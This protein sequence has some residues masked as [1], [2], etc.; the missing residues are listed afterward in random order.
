MSHPGWKLPKPV[1]TDRSL[2]REQE[3]QIECL[4]QEI[5]QLK[6]QIMETNTY[7]YK[8]AMRV[9]ALENAQQKTSTDLS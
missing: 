9:D 3:S 2:I 1:I 7:L 5:S 8:L 6:I 4:S